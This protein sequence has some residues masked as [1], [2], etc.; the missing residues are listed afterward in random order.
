MRGPPGLD[1]ISQFLARDQPRTSDLVL[2]V[3]PDNTIL[4]LH[5]Q[6]HIHLC[7]VSFHDAH[8]VIVDKWCAANLIQSSVLPLNPEL[9]PPE[10]CDILQF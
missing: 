3:L 2:D 8:L 6:R 9:W 7:N 1:C 4:L 5:L 10:H